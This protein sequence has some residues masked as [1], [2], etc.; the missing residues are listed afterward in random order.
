LDI[1][2][3]LLPVSTPPTATDVRDRRGV[4]EWALEA[5]PREVREIAFAFRLRWPKDKA[6]VV[7]PSG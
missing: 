5:K 1:Q 2:V 4:L 7:M 3:E 6:I